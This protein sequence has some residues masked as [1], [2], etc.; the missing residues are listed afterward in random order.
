MH[1]NPRLKH[2]V[3]NKSLRNPFNPGV[4]Q[5]ILSSSYNVRKD[6]R[7]GCHG[8]VPSR[9]AGERV[10]RQ[11]LALI[12]EADL[13]YVG[14]LLPSTLECYRHNLITTRKQHTSLE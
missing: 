9:S 11:V 14:V 4:L 1:G 6:L 3:V 12:M 7:D 2:K 10:D 13:G 5:R 8:I